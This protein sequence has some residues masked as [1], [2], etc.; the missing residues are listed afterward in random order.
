MV[1]K[2]FV[3]SMNL[4]GS[5]ADTPYKMTSLNVTSAQ[6]KNSAARRDFSPMTPVT[7]GYKGYWNFEHY[8]QAGK[9]WHN[10][11]HKVSVAW[12]RARD[13]PTRKLQLKQA[14]TSHVLYAVYDE[15]NHP[16]QYIE[17]RKQVYV[18]EYYALVADR[19]MSA[20]WRERVLNGEDVVVYDFDGPR[21]P[22]RELQCV[23]VTL[24]MLR[25]RIEDTRHPFGHGYVVAAMLL[26]IQPS[27]YV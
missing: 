6:A 7:G 12:W 26:G 21:G 9:V 18:P 2:V 25:E 27:E 20:H 10:I 3:A 24:E 16:L 14:K 13:V 4:R 19:P 5:R 22:E 23:E 11:P 8:W 15:K 1:G 17:A